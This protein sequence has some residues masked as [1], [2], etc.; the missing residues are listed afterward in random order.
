MNFFKV[1]ERSQIRKKLE[2][3]QCLKYDKVYQKI[4]TFLRKITSSSNFFFRLQTRKSDSPV[5]L[6]SDKVFKL[7]DYTL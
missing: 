7:I 6:I 2:G 5:I 4:S 1:R 3:I